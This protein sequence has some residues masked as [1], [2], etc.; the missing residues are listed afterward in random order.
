MEASDCSPLKAC[1]TIVNGT[2][3]IEWIMERYQVTADKDSGIRHDPNDRAREHHQPRYIGGCG[4]RLWERWGAARDG[5]DGGWKRAAPFRGHAAAGL[6][7]PRE[8]PLP[9]ISLS[10]AGLS[11]WMRALPLCPCFHFSPRSTSNKAASL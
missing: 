4:V 8:V 5:G 3:A 7:K 11:A 1:D 10:L 2:P 6:G 9:K